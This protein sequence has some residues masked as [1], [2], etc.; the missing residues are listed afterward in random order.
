[1]YVCKYIM[2][3]YKYQHIFSWR[4]NNFIPASIRASLP[5]IEEPLLQGALRVTLAELRL[6]QGALRGNVEAQQIAAAQQVEASR[7]G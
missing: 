2:Y 3:I 6:Q 5:S 1:M 7:F 4:Q